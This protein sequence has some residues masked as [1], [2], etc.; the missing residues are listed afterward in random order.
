[1]ATLGI[2]LFAV[3]HFMYGGGQHETDHGND[4][5]TTASF[6]RYTNTAIGVYNP[7]FLSDTEYETCILGT[8]YE[9]VTETFMNANP[10]KS[11]F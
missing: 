7:D 8:V 11:F 6:N 9:P 1:M 10:K 4:L 3:P 2:F 5:C